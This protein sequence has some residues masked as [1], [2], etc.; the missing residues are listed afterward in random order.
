MVDRK[1]VIVTAGS[2]EP[3]LESDR[4]VTIA[5]EVRWIAVPGSGVV[6]LPTPQRTETEHEAE[7][8]ATIAWGD[9]YDPNPIMGPH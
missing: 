7:I 2:G 5:S 9:E 3:T 6:M 1:L 8:A 4:V